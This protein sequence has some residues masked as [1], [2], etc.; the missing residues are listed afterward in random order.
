[1]ADPL[2]IFKKP[3]FRHGFKEP[4]TIELEAKRLPPDK[5]KPAEPLLLS[6]NPKGEK[7]MFRSL[8]S[9]TLV[10]GLVSGLFAAMIWFVLSGI[11]AGSMELWRMQMFSKWWALICVAYLAI[12]LLPAGK[13]VTA[14]NAG[15][16]VDVIT[17]LAPLAAT[18]YFSAYVFHGS[19]GPGPYVPPIVV[20]NLATSAVDIGIVILIW[21]LQ[22]RLAAHP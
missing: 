1:M 11:S 10:A 8:H 21:R 5:K 17:S 6:Y 12:Q 9:L 20:A 7:D 14:Q 4:I 19:F 18:L 3:P 16:T 15:L 2:I 22:R 13:A